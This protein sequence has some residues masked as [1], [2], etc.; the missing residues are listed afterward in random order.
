MTLLV[1]EASKLMVT[2]RRQFLSKAISVAPAAS[3]SA[4]TDGSGRGNGICTALADKTNNAARKRKNV[5]RDRF[6]R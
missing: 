1:E 6:I 2:V 4:N 5:L 3:V